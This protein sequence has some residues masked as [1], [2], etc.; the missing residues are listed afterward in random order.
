MESF[1][2][3]Y[4]D[5]VEI[6][7]VAAQLRFEAHCAIDAGAAR[8]AIAA[9]SHLLR[10]HL[11]AEDRAVYRRLL[12]CRDEGVADTARAARQSFATLAREWRRYVARWTA[13]AIAADRAGFA[14]ATAALLDRL[15][16]RVVFE[17]ETLYPLAVGLADLPL[18]GRAAAA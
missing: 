13:E 12:A 16:A 8:A 6:V 7:R 18:R 2:A 17:N 15:N 1:A 11:I 4:S 9:L 5:H 3:L 14:A 10:A